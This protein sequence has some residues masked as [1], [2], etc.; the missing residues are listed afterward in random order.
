MYY[1]SVGIRVFILQKCLL[2][3]TCPA[4]NDGVWDDEMT[5]IGDRNEAIDY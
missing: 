4:G 5:A 1:I 2:E 3:K